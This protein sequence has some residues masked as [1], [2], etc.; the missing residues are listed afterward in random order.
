MSRN[1]SS[2]FRWSISH[3]IM[4]SSVAQWREN[5]VDATRYLRQGWK[6]TL[7]DSIDFYFSSYCLDFPLP[8]LSKIAFTG[9]SASPC[10]K[11]DGGGLDTRSPD[12]GG[13]VHYWRGRDSRSD[14]H[15]AELVLHFCFVC[16]FLSCTFLSCTFLSC[17]FLSCTFLLLWQPIIFSR[18]I[19]E[20]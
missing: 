8:F 16:T 10:T 12:S 3:E 19:R 15:L 7:P 14:V 5:F 20:E 1:A 18:F 2:A 6:N 11:N 17:T 13:M 4:E 9:C